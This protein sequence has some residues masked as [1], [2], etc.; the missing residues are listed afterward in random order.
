MALADLLVNIGVKDGNLKQVISEDSELFKQ[1]GR[2]A[3][4]AAKDVKSEEENLTTLIAKSG[5]HKQALR[6]QVRY[7]QNLTMA[8]RELSAEE[9]NSPVGQEMARQLDSAKLKAAELTDSLADMQQEIRN[10]ADDEL[11]MK[12]FSQ[13]VGL[14]RDS[15]TATVTVMS[16]FNGEDEK[17]GKVISKVAA[18]M[19]SAN[20]V[21]SVFNALHKESYI[22]IV[23]TRL[24]NL[25]MT[26]SLVLYSAATG[27][28]A[29]ATGALA[30]A[31]KALPF[32]MI[33][34]LIATAITALYK[35]AS[36]TQEAEEQEK[37]KREAL[38]KTIRAQKQ[39]ATEV[40]TS[41]AKMVV[42]YSKLYKEFS[43]L[44]TQAQKTEWIKKNATEFSNLGM[45]VKTVT[46]AE[47]VFTGNTG[48]VVKALRMRAQ[49]M[50]LENKIL[51]ATEDF[52]TNDQMLQQYNQRV[53]NVGDTISGD[54]L[55]E[56]GINPLV[57]VG[58]NMKLDM[59]AWEDYEVTSKKVIDR[60]N[61][62]EANKAATANKKAREANKKKYDETVAYAEKKLNQLQKDN[63]VPN[64]VSLTES[65][66]NSNETNNQKKKQKEL[67]T[68]IQKLR[69]QIEKLEKARKDGLDTTEVVEYDQKITALKQKLADMEFQLT[70]DAS[71]AEASIDAIEKKY[72]ELTNFIS[73]NASKMT[74][75]QLEKYTALAKQLRQEMI[76]KGYVKSGKNLTNASTNALRQR[77]D[78]LKEKLQKSS[79]ATV[80]DTIQN[81]MREIE[82]Q[83][84][85]T[86]DTTKLED[87]NAHLDDLKSQL[88]NEDFK[89]TVTPEVVNIRAELDNI[90]KELDRRELVFGLDDE[91]LR[92]EL[93]SLDKRKEK[94]KLEPEFSSFDKATGEPQKFQDDMAGKNGLDS[95]L[96]ALQS[97]MDY[98][99]DLKAELMDLQAEYAKLGDLGAASYNKVGN[100]VK[101]VSD[102][103]E[104]LAE[105]TQKV[106]DKEKK[107]KKSAKVWSES[108]ELVGGMGDALQSLAAIA[109]DDKGLQVGA[110][111]AQA[112]AQVMMGYATATVAAA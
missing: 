19:T 105:T 78:N 74:K 62:Y 42:S 46:D 106:S 64:V 90:Q 34:G 76:D 83:I 69:D 13:G 5:N 48:A 52:Y 45:K 49:A 107:K 16:L 77:Q 32:M 110:I 79:G 37:K 7:V 43:N 29:V 100:M 71:P 40:G 23:A 14:M 92:K 3:S 87:L 95:Q 86:T 21:I 47:K 30:V 26:K 1:F 67:V 50:A 80:R 10:M 101:E 88:E 54:K 108:A 82:Y 91:K 11:N 70:L 20:A 35:Y 104:K 53:F 36:A 89:V 33:A 51:K 61:A 4:Q 84:K 12:A 27:K 38:E 103:Q 24:A 102:K 55:R 112:I 6:S 111:I 85:V 44:K 73:E 8:F 15:M 72:F 22:R 98:Y 109:D 25:M 58:V 99:D 31:Q 75:D 93:E 18:I 63:P 97:L 2:A 68:D 17:L 65:P 56:A 81:Q 28:A 39:Y 66:D 94:I 59:G 96:D 57:E 9:R 60:I 41:T